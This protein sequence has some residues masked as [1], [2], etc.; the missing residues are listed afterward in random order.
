MS[1]AMGCV[2]C[3]YSSDCDIASATLLIRTVEVQPAQK[4]L[5]WEMAMTL[6]QLGQ[7]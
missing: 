3:C 4:P 1:A 7:E 5:R 2:S 6:R